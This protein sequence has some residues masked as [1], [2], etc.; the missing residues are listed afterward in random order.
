MAEIRLTDGTWGIARLEG[1]QY[2]GREAIVYYNGIPY[3]LPAR[4][5]R[6]IDRE[7]AIM[8]LAE[9]GIKLE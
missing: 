6:E 9:M 4:D 2:G 5:V 3:K 1:W 8:L 7:R